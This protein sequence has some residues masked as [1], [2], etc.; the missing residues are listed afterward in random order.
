MDWR[1]ADN[2]LTTHLGSILVVLLVGLT[3][4]ML[5]SGYRP[6][7]PTPES[8]PADQ[9]NA[10]NATTISELKEA[11]SSPSTSI[12][13]NS[14]STSTPTGLV[15]INTASQAELETLPGIGPSKASAIISYRL[16]NGAFVRIDDLINVK[17]IGPKT[18]ESLRPLVSL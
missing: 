7:N 1:R 8:K 2:I 4:F 5:G 13:S 6:T 16:A 10:V 15:S 14:T 17:G 3:G 9:N 12:P 18:L 11:I